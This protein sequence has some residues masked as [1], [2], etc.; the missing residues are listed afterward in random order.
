MN[1]IES[2]EDNSNVKSEEYQSISSNSDSFDSDKLCANSMVKVELNVLENEEI[3]FENDQ[4]DDEE[5]PRPRQ[6]NL[7]NATRKENITVKK[8]TKTLK[9]VAPN[10][11][12][13]SCN[14][15]KKTFLRH[16][17]YWRHRKLHPCYTCYVCWKRCDSLE[18][19]EEHGMEHK[20]KIYVCDQD[21][22][23]LQFT[24]CK[25]F[26]LHKKNDHKLLNYLHCSKCDKTF[27]SHEKWDVSLN[28]TYC[29]L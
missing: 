6:Y 29:V 1:A 10:K 26:V 23:D 24:D 15:C 2:N 19:L 9:K 3:K 13:Y 27:G 16:N 4:S 22:C 20:N 5:I 21:T 8:K 12:T 25:M 17:R 11:V 14:S 28:F 7:R 18:S